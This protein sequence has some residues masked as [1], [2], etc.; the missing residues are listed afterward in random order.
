MVDTTDIPEAEEGDEV[1]LIGKDGEE[2]ITVRSWRVGGGF[3]YEILCDIG[4]RVPRV[5]IE[6]GK[7]VGKKDYFDDITKVSESNPKRK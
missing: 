5:Y 7:V 3:H 6:A 4:K 1:T 2:E